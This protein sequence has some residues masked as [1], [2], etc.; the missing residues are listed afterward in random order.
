MVLAT[1]GPY[2]YRD[3]LFL[4]WRDRQRVRAEHVTG[5][6]SLKFTQTKANRVSLQHKEFQFGDIIVS[7]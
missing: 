2:I 1:F 3:H 6:Q 4:L 5:T 7:R